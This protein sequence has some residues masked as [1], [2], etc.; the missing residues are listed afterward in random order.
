MPPFY[1]NGPAWRQAGRFVYDAAFVEIEEEV[2]DT[3]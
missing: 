3:G 2:K 1:R